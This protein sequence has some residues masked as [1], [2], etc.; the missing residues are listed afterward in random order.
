MKQLTANMITAGKLVLKPQ[1]VSIKIFMDGEECEFKTTLKPF[2]YETSVAQMRAFGEKRESL[3]D[4]LAVSI[5]NENGEPEFTAEHIRTCFSKELT[6][7]IWNK[8]VE[9]NAMGKMLSLNQKMNSSAKSQS[10]QGRQLH[11][12]NRR[13]ARNSASGR[14]T[15]KSTAVSTSEDASNKK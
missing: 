13:R 12:P 11:K 2:S 1:A 5:L 6:D 8:L 7:A 3:A 14:P 15:S 4:I 10:P 9:V